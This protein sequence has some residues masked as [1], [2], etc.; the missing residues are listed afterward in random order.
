M[1]RREELSLRLCP[2][3]A[4]DPGPQI[5]PH[6]ERL[7]SNQSH[8]RQPLVWVKEEESHPP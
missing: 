6:S 3:L 5:T 2:A 4:E 8:I 7:L 1:M